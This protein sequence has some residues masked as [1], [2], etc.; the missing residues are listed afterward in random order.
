MKAIK[1]KL[2]FLLSLFGLFMAAG[3]VVCIPSNVEPIM[4]FVIFPVCAFIIS[5]KAEGKYFLHGLLLGLANCV[6]ITS[7]HVIFSDAY[8][9][10]HP[11]EA[12][13]MKTASLSPKI[14]MLLTGPV[15]GIVSGI[16]FGLFSVVLNRVFRKAELNKQRRETLTKNTE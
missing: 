1:W 9:A 14:M 11:E 8:L 4:W 2:V 15:I 10:F 5:K 12:A 3:T 6:W 7:A 13:M 16:V